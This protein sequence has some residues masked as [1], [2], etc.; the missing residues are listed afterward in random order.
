MNHLHGKKEKGGGTEE[1]GRGIEGRERREKKRKEDREIERGRKG[2]RRKR[3][4]EGWKSG[5]GAWKR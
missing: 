1:K 4:E 2:K 3:R 5:E